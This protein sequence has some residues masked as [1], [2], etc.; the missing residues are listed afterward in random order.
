MFCRG[1]CNVEQESNFL[2]TLPLFLLL[3]KAIISSQHIRGNTKQERLQFINYFKTRMIITHRPKA[4][5]YFCGLFLSAIKDR[6]TILSLSLSCCP[7]FGA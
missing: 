6:K 2:F 1:T 3:I 7:H 5:S 4:V